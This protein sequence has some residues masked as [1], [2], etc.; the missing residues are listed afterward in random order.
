MRW[1]D[2]AGRTMTFAVTI[3]RLGRYVLTGGSAAVVDLGVFALLKSAGVS[4][5]AA[6]ACSFGLAA[7]WNYRLTS[8]FVFGQAPSGRRFAGFLVFAMAGLAVNVGVTVA[9]VD[10]ASIAPVEAKILGIGVA[11]LFNF[12][13]NSLVVFRPGDAT[14][15]QRVGLNAWPGRPGCGPELNANTKGAA[16]ETTAAPN[17]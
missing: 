3:G 4:V 12:T 15:N 2:P 1:P 16:I 8:R 5:P 6:A 17:A 13:L 7:V 9:A 11:F 10:F 14:A